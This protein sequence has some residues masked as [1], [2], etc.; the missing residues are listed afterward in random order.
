M[1]FGGNGAVVSPWSVSFFWFFLLF[2][3][4]SCGGGEEMAG[5]LPTEPPTGNCGAPTVNMITVKLHLNSVISTKNTHYCTIDL[6]DFYLNTPMDRLEFM[7]RKLSNLSPNFVKFYNL[8]NLAN[9]GG[10][11]YVRI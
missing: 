3:F 9:D 1:G 6:K 2:N 8:T 11:I 5:I 10:T 7:R 4:V